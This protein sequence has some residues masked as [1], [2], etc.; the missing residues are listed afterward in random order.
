MRFH[1]P[2]FLWCLRERTGRCFLNEALRSPGAANRKSRARRR[3]RCTWY[4]LQR[5]R[6]GRACAA[7]GRVNREICWCW[8]S[9]FSSACKRYPTLAWLKNVRSYTVEFIN[10]SHAACNVPAHEY[11]FVFT[12][13]P[14]PYPPPLLL[15]PDPLSSPPPSLEPKDSFRYHHRCTGLIRA[16]A[17]VD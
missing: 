2:V 11:F 12:P 14:Y 8:C 5:E 9:G 16:M 13:C 4:H 17:S 15:P 1:S 3:R 10:I 6:G 7:S